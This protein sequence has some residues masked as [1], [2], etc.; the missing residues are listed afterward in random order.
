MN[1]SPTTH[2]GALG[3]V[4]HVLRADP[5][6]VAELA[7]VDWNRHFRRVCLD[8]V[9]GAITLM[10][11]SRLHE[12][13]TEIL[14]RIVDAAGSAVADA[15]KGLRSTRLRGRD[16]PPGTGMEPDCAFYVGERAKGYY[17]A[18]AEGEAAVESFDERIAPDLVVET[19]ITSFDEGKIARYGNLG[20]RELW[21]L[22]GCKGSDELRVDFLALR[23]GSAP[24]KLDASRVLTGLTPEDVYEAVERVRFGQTLAERAEAVSRIVLRRQQAIARVR[25]AEARYSANP[26]RTENAPAARG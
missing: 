24:R 21:R 22:Y 4:I 18:C 26:R 10:A 2:T 3:S 23:A 19:E 25:E 9:R 1:D 5:E 8:P 17:G 13:L 6:T 12:D 14:D 20:V 11:P 15:V 7:A 16:D